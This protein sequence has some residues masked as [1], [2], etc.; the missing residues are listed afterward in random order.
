MVVL[1][2]LPDDTN[3]HTEAFRET[4]RMKKDIH[5][6]IQ[7]SVRA[8]TMSHNIVLL[9]WSLRSYRETKVRHTHTHT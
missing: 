4:V 8:S 2:N 1:K 6:T 9:V 3:E 5:H 7:E